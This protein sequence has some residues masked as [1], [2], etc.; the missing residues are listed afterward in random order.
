MVHR[1]LIPKFQ[2]A[3]AI[4]LLS[5]KYVL[6]LRDSKPTI[7]APGQWSLFGGKMDE[8]ET[9]LQTVQREIFEELAIKPAKYVELPP[10]EYYA[11]FEKADVR[12]WLFASDV[13]DV[14]PG[15]QLKEGQD[16]RAFKY[17]ELERLEIPS[18]MREAIKCFH[19]I[20]DKNISLC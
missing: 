3:H 14:W 4:L 16:V 13:T 18:M 1:G 20:K 7:S 2:T 17:D 8:E 5:G 15:H 11:P 9:P 12:T 6:Q 10:I 19:N